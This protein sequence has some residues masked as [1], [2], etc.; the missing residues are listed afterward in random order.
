MLGGTPKQESPMPFVPPM[1]GG[2]NKDSSNGGFN[3]DDL[4]KRID[5]KIAELE[6][7]E[8]LEREQQE[9]NTVE[10]KVPE[11]PVMETVKEEIVIP[12]I[13]QHEI[14]EETTNVDENTGVE[15]IPSVVASEVILDNQIEEV[16]GNNTAD[17]VVSSKFITDD[18]FFDDFFSEDE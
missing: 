9:K 5:A 13:P 3:V 2:A 8:R 10:P 12:N 14:I 4:V 16:T 15:E 6:E 1:F 18:Q 11:N 7:E 17:N